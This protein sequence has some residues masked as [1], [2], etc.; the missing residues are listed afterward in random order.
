MLGTKR[1][2]RLLSPFQIRHV[3]L[4]NRIMSPAHTLYFASEEGYVTDTMI[5]SYEALARGGVGLIV[6]EFSCVDYPKGIDGIRNVGNSD[7]KY[8]P[9]LSK[10]TQ[11]IH[12]SDCPVFLQLAHSGPAAAPVPGIRRVSSSHL[13][14]D[15]RPAANLLAKFAPAEELTISEIENLVDKFARAAERAQRAGFDG[16]E[17]HGAH[18]YLV[19]SFL[20]RIW[21][22]RRDSYGCQELSTRAKFATEII[23]EIKERLGPDFPVGIRMNGAEYGHEKG[24]TSQESQ[25]FAKMFEK[26]GADYLS[27]SSW[28]YGDYIGVLA[29]EQLLYPEPKEKVMPVAKLINRPGALVPLADAVKK[30][31]SIPVIAVG[32]LDHN[33]GEWILKENKADLIGM[34][35]RLM[36]DPELPN[37]VASGKL[38]DIA[39]CTAC[40]ECTSRFSKDK[41]IRCRI[42]ASLGREL[43]HPIKGAMNKKKILVVGGGPAGMEAARVAALRGHDVF[44][45]EKNRKLGGLLPIAA[46]IKGLEIEDI[47]ALV[48]YFNTQLKNLGVEIRLGEEVNLAVIEDIKPDVVVIAAGGIVDIPQI[49]GIDGHNV[50]K[51]SDLY[52]TLMFYMRFLGPKIL[53]FLTRFWMPLGEKIIVIGGLIQGCELAEFLVKRGRKVTVVEKSEELG[54]GMPIRHKDILIDWLGKKGV[55]MLAGVTYEEISEKGL[56]IITK[57][58]KTQV[59]EADNICTALPFQPNIELLQEIKGRFS[60]VHRIGDAGD[61]PQRMIDA[62]ADGFRVGCTI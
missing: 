14:D 51:T 52:R 47:V 37:K 3:K 58:G 17:V 33:L 1:F 13:S 57:E 53:R 34:V 29:P 61:V 35:R 28:G 12:K 10:L 15:E 20:S 6:I 30:A 60:E 31:V 21:N 19:N 54:T 32:R 4:R 9:G 16:V 25:Q 8:I 22:K 46:L 27:V 55:S 59:L 41:P 49:P 62:I 2:D 24:I 48:R 44:L 40:T 36:A 5:A 39:P 42:N 11:A 50:I 7:D 26:T 43:E 45:F 23:H 56:T 18:P 38:K